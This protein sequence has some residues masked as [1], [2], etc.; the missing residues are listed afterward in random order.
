VP[1]IAVFTFDRRNFDEDVERQKQ[2]K[3]SACRETKI[4][5]EWCD[6][7]MAEYIALSRGGKN[8]VSQ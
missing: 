3:E 4:L 5:G 6:N 7:E 2:G 1:S 8:T